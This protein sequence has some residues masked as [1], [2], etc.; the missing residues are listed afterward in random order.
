M[1]TNRSTTG[2]QTKLT[3]IEIPTKHRYTIRLRT[4]LTKKENPN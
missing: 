4:K 3:K 1:S 2:L